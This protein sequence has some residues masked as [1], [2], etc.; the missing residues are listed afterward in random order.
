MDIIKLK[1]FVSVAKYLNFTKA[2]N[3]NHIAQT[4]M[5][6]HIAHLEAE[7][8]VL[9]FYRDNRS[10]ELT[11]AGSK[12]YFEAS[13]LLDYYDN[14]I[15]RVKN[16]ALNYTSNLKIGVGT[17]DRYL[18]SDPISHFSTTYPKVEISID[19]YDYK[20]LSDK[21]VQ[22][23]L[24]IVF[25]IDKYTQISEDILTITINKDPWKLAVNVEHPFASKSAVKS[26]EMNNQ[27]LIT[28]NNGSQDDIMGHS[29]PNFNFY[30]YIR[31]NSLDAKLLLVESN[32]GITFLPAIIKNISPKIKFLDIKSAFIPRT[33][34]VAYLKTNHNPALKLFLDI[35]DNHD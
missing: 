7:L 27:R 23:H 13:N 18:A 22:G 5:S 6:R 31:V 25:C 15:S 24:D 12:L 4:A 3:E 20:T 30:D 26:N 9:L 29:V 2:A 11:S 33:F 28:M 16:S 14:A 17:Y 32:L 35:L 19:Q 10:V 8:G 21:L 34:V 1:Y